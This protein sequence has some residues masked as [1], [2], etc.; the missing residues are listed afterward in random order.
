MD[1]YKPLTQKDLDRGYFFVT[2]RKMFF[3]ILYGVGIFVLVIL[4]GYLIFGLVRYFGGGTYERAA[5]MLEAQSINW[6]TYHHNRAPLPLDAS[7]AQSMSLGDRRYNLVAKV[8]ND[9]PDWA[10]IDFEYTFVVNGEP[11]ETSSTFLNPSESRYVMALSHQSAAAIK[12]V[13]LE[14]GNVSWKRTDGS[15]PDINFEI[16]NV[17]FNPANRIEVDGDVID[18]PARVT[19]QAQN[20]TLDN[21]WEIG[22]QVVLYNS[23]RVVGVNTLM[24][25]DFLG[26]EKREMEVVWLD[27]LPRV[28][29]VEVFPVMDKLDK[30]NIKELYVD[31]P[32]GNLIGI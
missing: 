16:E 10:I 29:K 8:A 26:M 13:E 27:K 22:W 28:T 1:D 7:Q 3:K 20:N 9:N 23:S 5:A 18:V 17:K 12:T 24:S 25:Q 30:D 11:V 15:F 19:W 32:D 4:Y 2:H 6:V 21:F 31:V 14:I